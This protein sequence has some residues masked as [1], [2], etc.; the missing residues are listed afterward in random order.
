MPKPEEVTFE[1]YLEAVKVIDAWVL[2]SSSNWNDLSLRPEAQLQ[3]IVRAL[4]CM[5]RTEQGQSVLDRCATVIR[6][7]DQM[8]AVLGH[9]GS[10]VKIESTDGRVVV[11][12]ESPPHPDFPDFPGPQHG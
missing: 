8:Y 4:R 10:K 3:G 6:R 9:Y 7:H 5:L 1:Q 12:T 11:K 2:D